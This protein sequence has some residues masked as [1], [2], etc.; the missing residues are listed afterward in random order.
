[1]GDATPLLPGGTRGIKAPALIVA[2]EFDI[3]K[4]EH[5]DQLARAIPA[6]EEFIIPGATHNVIWER[7]DAVNEKIL[8][9]LDGPIPP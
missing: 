7:T 2:G 8:Q 3:A 9:F 5:T 6:G 1:M 4:R